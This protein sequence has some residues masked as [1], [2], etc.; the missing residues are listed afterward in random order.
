VIVEV[1]R[2]E[3]LNTDY[4][5][6]SEWSGQAVEELTSIFRENQYLAQLP[7]AESYTIS[8]RDLDTARRSRHDFYREAASL[9]QL[10]RDL[11][12]GQYERTQVQELLRSTL[13]TPCEPARLFELYSIFEV[14]EAVNSGSLEYQ[15]VEPG[16]G[17]IAR[18]ESSESVVEV[19][20]DETGPVTLFEPL[21][22]LKSETLPD[23]FS[24]ELAAMEAYNR[25]REAILGRGSQEN[26][27]R[28]RPDIVVCIFERGSNRRSL[29][30]VMIGEVK[31][32]RRE[33]T[34][35]RGLRDISEYLQF[36]CHD[37]TY[38]SESDVSLSG[39]VV[40]NQPGSV[41]QHENIVHVGISPSD[42]NWKDHIHRLLN[43]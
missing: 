5:W 21:P 36:A 14:L 8:T 41:D 25:H 11:L 43:I 9:L 37:E 3:L 42:S 12:D 13:I 16:T 15:P 29:Q 2:A 26:Y 33:V 38:L 19:Y 27:Y 7:D 30:T 34:L 18:L 17:A 4:D 28:G 40:T 22:S 20:H 31:Y 23:P 10:Y 6:Q 35:S 24:R 32:T 39:L 1:V